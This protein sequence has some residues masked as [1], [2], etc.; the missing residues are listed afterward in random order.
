MVVKNNDYWGND[1]KVEQNEW[2]ER[3]EKDEKT[4]IQL[5]K[6]WEKVTTYLPGQQVL[7]GISSTFMMYNKSEVAVLGSSAAVTALWTTISL[8]VVGYKLNESIGEASSSSL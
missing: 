7:S 4:M 3:E 1:D 5:R 6:Y 8:F 2:E